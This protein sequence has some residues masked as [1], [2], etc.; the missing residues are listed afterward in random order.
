MLAA[1]FTNKIHR[2][3]KRLMQI[4]ISRYYTVYIR[5][6]KKKF[7]LF[8]IKIHWKLSNYIEKFHTNERYGITYGSFGLM[9][10]TSF[11]KFI[12]I[13]GQLIIY[14]YQFMG[15]RKTPFQS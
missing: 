3:V 12:L 5:H 10:F 15:H 4:V 2:F 7:Q 11:T 14:W 8:S 9:S 6:R 13:Y 1:M